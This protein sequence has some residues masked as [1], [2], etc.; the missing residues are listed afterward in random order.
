[1][2][3]FE[4]QVLSTWTTKCHGNFLKAK[5][6]AKTFACYVRFGIFTSAMI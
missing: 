2:Q 4:I 1:M 3:A 6:S 5:G